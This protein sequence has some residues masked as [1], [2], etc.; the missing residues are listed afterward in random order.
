MIDDDAA[1]GFSDKINNIDAR[2]PPVPSHPRPH[3]RE[4]ARARARPPLHHLRL[5]W[6]RW[7]CR[8]LQVQA[9]CNNICSFQAVHFTED[10]PMGRLLDSDDP[11][12]LADRA[13]EVSDI[14]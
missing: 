14:K 8:L 6:H 5:A 7:P 12:L 11:C 10:V 1:K 13:R 4:Q 2:H 3:G 9:A